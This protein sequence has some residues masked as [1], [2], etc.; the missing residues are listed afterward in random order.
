[1]K[2]YLPFLALSVVLWNAT[3]SVVSEA[4][5]AFTS[6]EASIRSMRLPFTVHVGRLMVRQFLI[7]LHNALVVLVVFAIFR[8]WPGKMIVMAVP[9]TILWL[10]DWFAAGLVL[11]CL[12]ARFR[13][14]PQ[15]VNSVMQIAFYVTPVVWR[16]EQMKS[17]ARRLPFNPFYDLLEVVR[18]PLFG[19]SPSLVVWEFAIGYTVLLCLLAWVTFSWARGRLAFWI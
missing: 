5:T 12:C 15:I 17:G 10:V 8:L 18:G 11:G 13:D 16:P 14:I 2:D 9:G 4:C 6:A 19:A 3:A 1:L 7:F